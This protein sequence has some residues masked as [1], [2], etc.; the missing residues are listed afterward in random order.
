[1]DDARA[2]RMADELLNK[3]VGNWTILE[4]LGAGKSALVFKAQNSTGFAALKIF[5][6][7]L[8]QRFGTDVQTARIDREL[9]LRGKH[10]PHLVDILDGGRC[11]VTGF[12]FVAMQLLDGKSLSS[13]LHHFPR[14]RIWPILTQLSSAAQFLESL[15]LVHRD[16]KPDNIFI[17]KDFSH[18]WL[19]DFGV[20]RPIGEPGLTD[21]DQK[22]FIGTLQYSSPEFLF[23]T[24]DDTPAGWR[25]LT[26]YQIGAVLHDLIM[27]E[28]IFSEY[29]APFARL[30]EAV[31]GI[32]PRVEATDVAPEL[33]LLAR[34]CLSKEPTLRLRLVSWGAFDPHDGGAA[35]PSAAKDRI[36]NRQLLAR[37]FHSA[38]QTLAD[39]TARTVR[40]TIDYVAEKVQ[41]LVRMECVGSGLFPPLQIIDWQAT[42]PEETFFVV[43]F[44]ASAEHALDECFQ[45][46]FSVQLLDQA[47]LSISISAAASLNTMPIDI[48]ACVPQRKISLYEGPFDEAAVETKVRSLLYCALDKAQ[49]TQ[50]AEKLSSKEASV[51][52]LDCEEADTK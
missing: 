10:H 6:P 5:D 35:S 32:T 18:A 15:D 43:T 27:R 46:W 24:E 44:E 11:P 48:H 37:G 9:S 12:F 31:K 52:W 20:I 16:I 49:Q 3:T 30:V 41:A 45:L 13:Q 26:F 14:E 8:V 39:Q 34:S 22:P 29:V 2:A 50:D 51:I 38:V 1:M 17:T 42:E 47:S 28:R 25:A 21:G 23:R 36:I 4:F 40:R 7:E 33:V 19:L